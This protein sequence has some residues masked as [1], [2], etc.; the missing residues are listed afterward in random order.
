MHQVSNE[1]DDKKD[2]IL[3]LIL[4]IIL[5]FAYMAVIPWTRTKIKRTEDIN[6]N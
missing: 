1:N 2:T 6:V 5:F 4:S 3:L